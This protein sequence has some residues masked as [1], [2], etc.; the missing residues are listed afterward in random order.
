MP[1]NELMKML[2]ET[3][4]LPFDPPSTHPDLPRNLVGNLSTTNPNAVFTGIDPKTG[5]PTNYAAKDLLNKYDPPKHQGTLLDAASDFF[6][7][8]EKK[9]TN[10][11]DDALA[12][13]RTIENDLGIIGNDLESFGVSVEKTSI[14][15]FDGVENA[16]VSLFN[17]TKS[18]VLFVERNYKMILVGSGV[19]VMARFFNEVKQTFK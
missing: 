5:V 9:V 7:K 18:S 15:V 4:P 11:W 1:N 2:R 12:V 19:F 8:E 16:S 10:V 14:R 13:G 17:M 6:K 3:N